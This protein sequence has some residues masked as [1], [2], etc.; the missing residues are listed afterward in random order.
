MRINNSDKGFKAQAA[1]WDPELTMVHELLHLMICVESKN[2]AE[3]FFLEQGI[4]R[5]AR[6]FMEVYGRSF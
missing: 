3:D 2:L 6:V 4:E 5:T 1:V